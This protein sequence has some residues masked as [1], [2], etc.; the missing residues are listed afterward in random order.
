MNIEKMAEFLRSLREDKGLTQDQLGDMLNVSRSL[1]SKW[2]HASKIPAVDCLMSL[3]KIYDITIDEIIYG[4]RKNTKNA[5]NIESLSATIMNESKKKI[6]IAHKSIIIVTLV[7]SFLLLG[8]Y[9]IFNYNS[10]K[11]YSVGARND[12]YDIKN[13][14]MIISKNK[15]YIKFGDI[16][17]S[18]EHGD[19]EYDGYEFYAKDG[20]NKIVLSSREDGATL[21]NLDDSDNYLNFENLEK[22]IDDLYV[23]IYYNDEVETVK[24]DTSLEMANNKIFNINKDDGT[25]IKEESAKNINKDLPN[26]V[27]EKFIYDFDNNCYKFSLNNSGKEIRYE[28]Y[29]D[30]RKMYIY[31]DEIQYLYDYT[32]EFIYIMSTKNNGYERLATYDLKNNECIMFD[33]DKYA[34]L[35]KNFRDN[36]YELIKK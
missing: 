7:L 22:F 4:E 21:R 15:S 34:N 33:C 10:I 1:V 14:L 19:K 23:D 30:T 20:D 5:K 17:S 29:E 27:Q 35:I 11:V 2:E 25:S 16:V 31:I 18:N 12:K 28:Y 13:T 32:N 8:S 26:F 3:S 6:D 9:F 36:Y 24:L